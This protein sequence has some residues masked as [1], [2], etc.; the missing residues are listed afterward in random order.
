MKKALLFLFFLSIYF[1][2][3]EAQ[4]TSI[5]PTTAVRGRSLTTNITVAN[6]VF[7]LASP[8]LNYQDIYLQQ[9]S[10]IIYADPSYNMFTNVYNSGPPF[11]HDSLYTIFNI[12]ANAPVGNYDVN[13]NSYN[14][15][16]P[17]PNVLTNG[18]LVRDYIGTIE[19]TVYSDTNQNG[20][21]DLNEPPLINHRVQISPTGDIGFTDQNGHYKFYVDSGNYTVSYIP[22][23]NYVQTS[24]PTTY[25]VHITP[26]V[27]GQDFGA[28]SNHI[29]G[30]EQLLLVCHQPMRCAP[31]YGNTLI[32]I[33]NIDVNS[34][35]GNINLIHSSNMPFVS[36]IPPPDV[37]S[38]DTLKWY[39]SNLAPGARFEIGGPMIRFQD[40]AAGQ[41]VWYRIIDSITNSAGVSMRQLTDSF[42]YVTICSYDPNEKEVSPVGILSPHYIPM[43]SELTYSL[44]FQNTGNDTAFNVI[45]YDSLDTHLDPNT[46]IL[47][48]SSHA[49]DVQMTSTGV[50]RF[51]FTNILL[52]DSGAD[53]EGSSGFVN[54]SIRPDS[55]LPDPTVVHNTAYIVFDWNAAVR[56]NTRTNTFTATQ[57]PHALFTAGNTTLCSNN[58]CITFINQSQNGTTYRWFFPGATPD[59]STA[60]NPTNICYNGP[61][62]YNVRLITTNILGS[63]TLNQPN[64]ISVTQSPAAPTFT[65][66][67]DTLFGPPGL[68]GYQWYLDSNLI[69]GSNLYY[70]V[71]LQNGNYN[72]IVTDSNGCQAGA[73]ILN[74]IIGVSTINSFIGELYVFPNPAR[75]NF[76]VQFVG[77][78]P[79]IA[80]I[81]IFNSI[82][83]VVY[84]REINITAGENKVEIY[85][86]RMSAGIYL[87]K[88]NDGHNVRMK[89]VVIE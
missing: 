43:N 34:E 25:S 89:N 77:T 85:G 22:S 3:V 68:A 27:T 51:A 9:G 66:H 30:F 32:R 19:G 88:I 26:S 50:V 76:E 18:F 1:L 78:K 36:S 72:L 58:S 56:T 54:Y 67:G 71:A 74:V 29:N 80:R 10:T 60:A 57:P 70:H 17:V 61:G 59:T 6:G 86:S 81:E 82:D 44:N 40:P 24:V 33:T 31:A 48:G 4:V 14:M 39:Y 55:L 52:P 16:G 62:H 7:S 45:V 12:P 64:F 73:G 2:S 35:D 5:R 37:I 83:Q 11:W 8:P 69:I 21:R 79:S 42:G 63:D 53:E 75:G 84:S 38:G 20:I 41:T 87:L 46:F 28:Y 15:S 13:V 49:V 47:L 65:Q 23:A